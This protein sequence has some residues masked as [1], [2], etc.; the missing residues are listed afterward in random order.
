MIWQGLNFGMTTMAFGLAS[1]A[2]AK[3]GHSKSSYR[4][5]FL[6]VHISSSLCVYVCMYMILSNHS[7]TVPVQGAAVLE[8]LETPGNKRSRIQIRVRSVNKRKLSVSKAVNGY[9]FRIR[10]EYGSERKGMVMM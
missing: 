5:P 4:L 8:G 10:K 1:Q 3:T 7:N 6:K 9:L 2:Q